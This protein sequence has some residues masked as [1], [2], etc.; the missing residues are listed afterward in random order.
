MNTVPQLL[1]ALKMSG[2]LSC[3]QSLS[4]RIQDR[5][6]LLI[7]LLETEVQCRSERALRRRL[8]QAKFPVEKEWVE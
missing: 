5:E 2:A 6:Q 1:E 3:Y 8:S 7:R 4:Q